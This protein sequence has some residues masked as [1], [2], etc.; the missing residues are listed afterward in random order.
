MEENSKENEKEIINEESK[1]EIEQILI[2]DSPNNISNQN[3]NIENSCPPIMNSEEDNKIKNEDDI[4]VE[5]DKNNIINTNSNNYNLNNIFIHSP[6]IKKNKNPLNLSNLSKEQKMEKIEKFLHSVLSEVSSLKEK[7]NEFYNNNNYEAAEKKYS[8]GIR[9]INDSSILPEIDELNVQIND[10]LININ[11]LNLQL[12]NNLSAALIKQEKYEET[13]NNCI[14]I[15]ENLSQDHVV[16]YCRI[17][18]CL[19]E[20]K[21]VILANHYAEII[22]Q[23]FGNENSFS[24]FQEQLTR[25]EVLN[26]EFSEQLLN[27]NPELKKEII[28]MNDDLNTQNEDNKKEENNIMKYMPY[29]LG[30][31]VLFYIG[32]RFLYKKL[33]K[34]K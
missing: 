25:L 10:Y 11:S 8:E 18:F 15:L 26:K 1:P 7:G 4:K 28:S 9:K 20:T 27:P 29:I 5:D 24:K 23:K 22:R 14:F 30:G 16:S 17:L 19:I 21:K 6:Q 31:A 13:I 34:N 2:N 12:Y 33:K 3:N 32:G